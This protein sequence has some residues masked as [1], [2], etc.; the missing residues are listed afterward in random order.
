MLPIEH[1]V[2]LFRW[3]FCCPFS[4]SFTP[5]SATSLL[6][7]SS[8]L[9]P[10]PY[11]PPITSLSLLSAPQSSPSVF[12]ANCQTLLTTRNQAATS[13]PRPPTHHQLPSSSPH[14]LS[15]CNL[16]LSLSKNPLTIAPI[17]SQG[18]FQGL[19]SE[20]WGR[21]AGFWLES[22][23]NRLVYSGDGE[24]RWFIRGFLFLG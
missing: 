16:P 4:P 23:H 11:S 3:P 22:E 15:L 8:S 9:T 21:M 12:S 7:L 17:E 1:C 20:I 6:P 18:R 10:L 13:Q 5:I 24:I 14:W 2:Y 19:I